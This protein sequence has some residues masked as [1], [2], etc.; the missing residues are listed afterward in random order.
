MRRASGRW[1]GAV[2]GSSSFASSIG[3]GRDGDDVGLADRQVHDREDDQGEQDQARH[4]HAEVQPAVG[5]RLRHEVA[6]RGAQRTGEDVGEPE[7]E[8]R[9]Q[10]ESPGDRD[11]ADE[12]RA[13]QAGLEVADAQALGDQVADGGAQREGDQDREPV[14]RLTAAGVD[15]VDRQGLLARVPGQEHQAQQHGEDDRAHLQ[16]HPEV[17]GEVVRE[18]R[19]EDADQHHRQ[20]VDRRDVAA[21]PDLER[22][23]REEHHSRDDRRVRQAPVQVHV[24]EVSRGLPHR[25]AQDLDDPEEDRHLGDLVQDPTVQQGRARRETVPASLSS[26]GEARNVILRRS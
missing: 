22:E 1:C 17:V 21:Q 20:P 11:D 2:S 26:C 7:G 24:Q 19:A 16:R 15:R 6:D 23:D 12:P 5:G 13:Q 14:E 9:V 10:P 25:R 18:E 4:R 8:D 3:V